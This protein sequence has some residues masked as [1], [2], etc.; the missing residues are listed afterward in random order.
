MVSAT[1]TEVDILLVVEEAG[2]IILTLL[3]EEAQLVLVV[4]LVMV[5]LLKEGRVASS[6]A[7]MSI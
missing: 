4:L 5:A 1:L 7:C 3:V 2:S 6:V